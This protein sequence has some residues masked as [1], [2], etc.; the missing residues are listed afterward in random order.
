MRQV[1][2]TK[3]DPASQK[4]TQDRHRKEYQCNRGSTEREGEKRGEG[5][6][7]GERKRSRRSTEIN[8]K[9][10]MFLKQGFSV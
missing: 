5:R 6:E 1:W 4:L 2:A 3:Q 8:S 10:R 7:G 9:Q